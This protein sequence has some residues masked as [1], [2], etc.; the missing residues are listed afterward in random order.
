MDN[1]RTV[2]RE[3]S[4]GEGLRALARSL[5]T[6]VEMVEIGSYAGSSTL[7][8]LNNADVKSLVAVDPWNNDLLEHIVARHG[9]QM[10]NVRRIFVEDVMSQYSQVEM[11]A[12]TSEKAA[13]LV[14]NRMFDFV[15]ID[16]DHA[17]ES[18]KRDIELW[19]PKI[20]PE[21]MIGG[22]DYCS[23]CPGVIQAV[24]E[25]FGKPDET[26]IDNSWLKRLS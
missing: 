24:D 17:Y 8:F 10:D 1:P 13:E 22:H 7:I 19:L 23:F 11:L 5:P 26:F 6:N 2:M 20:R 12:M 16:G 18:C 3:G 9:L 15:Y 4:L 21:G 14:G 25:R